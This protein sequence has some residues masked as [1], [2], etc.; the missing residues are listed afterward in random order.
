M[1]GRSH[2][3]R[4]LRVALLAARIYLGY[5]LISL[6]EKRLG[7]SSERAEALRR[8]HH[9]WS[10]RNIYATA[11]RLQ[12]PMIKLAQV[13]GSRPD[14]VPD[15]Y[16]QVLSRLQDRVPPRPY[17]VVRQ[18]LEREL[19]RPEE[20]FTEFEP[21]P[22]AA[23]S[24]AQVH[25]ARLHDGRRVAVK[26]QYPDMEGVVRVDLATL[27][28]LL[29]ILNRLERGLDFMPI[30][31]ELQEF[32]PQELDFLREAENAQAMARVFADWPNVVVPAVVRECT[33]RRVLV[34]E[35]VDGVKVSDVAA[36][37]RLGIDPQQ[38]AQLLLEVYCQQIL[39][40]GFFNADPHPGNF[41][42]Q[43]GPRL[44]LLDFGLCRRLPPEFHRGY[45]RLTRAMLTGQPDELVQAFTDLGFRTQR[46]DPDLLV[47]FRE[48]F[49][50]RARPG[51]AYADGSLVAAADAR[52]LRLF[53]QNPLV[54]YPREVVLIMRA[55][56]LLSGLGRS[57]D[58]RADWIGLTL[59]YLPAEA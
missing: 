39:V 11:V 41:L 47:A 10:A 33:T 40:H 56:G 16:V 51:Y 46:W 18:V 4:A 17:S 34:L 13:I 24:W 49:L 57:L 52:L 8:S 1:L 45:L 27:R 35:Y 36:M 7:L 2:L 48:S 21:E 29:S 59:R 50:A 6:R 23:A 12:G 44:V 22:V 32:I 37:Q 43:P 26:V 31:E 58:S 3:A 9:T 38:V 30:V 54:G 55:V 20:V 53:R 19:G 25:R 42:V 5:K 15:E 14:L 28:L